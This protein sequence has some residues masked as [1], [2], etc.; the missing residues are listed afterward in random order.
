MKNDDITIKDVMLWL[1]EQVP[2]GQT[3]TLIMTTDQIEVV[4]VMHDRPAFDCDTAADRP[5]PAGD[6]SLRWPV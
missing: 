4:K 2:E 5:S 1:A 3:T 6:L